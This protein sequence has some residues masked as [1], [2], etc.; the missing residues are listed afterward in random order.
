MITY[1]HHVVSLVAVFL[2][3]AVG[4]VLGGGPLSELGRDDAQPAPARAV[5]QQARLAAGYGDTFATAAAEQLYDGRLADRPVALLAM[6]GADDSTVAGL[7]EQVELA[8]GAVTG[9]YDV[10]PALLAASE[11]ALV[12]TLGSQLA[13]DLGAGVV[14]ADAST[15]ARMGQLLGVALATTGE[16]ASAPTDETRTVRQSLAAAE[17]VVSPEGETPRAPAVVVVLGDSGPTPATLAVL[18]GLLSGAAETSRGVVVAGTTAAARAGG[19]LAALRREPV[20]DVVTTVDGAEN[21][22]GQVTTVLG[23]LRRLAGE[24]G[25]FGASGADGAVP[26]G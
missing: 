16:Q 25:E 22:L 17:L 1:R 7:T 11:K 19:L 8:G 12:D 4:V 6:P 2:A 5:T 3:L 23:V 14:D 9:R 20:A 21:A 10:Q 18:D 13:A 26:L 15:Y 24:G